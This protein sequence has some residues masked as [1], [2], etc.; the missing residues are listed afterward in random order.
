MPDFESGAFNRAASCVQRYGSCN[1]S[2][3]NSEA[4]HYIQGSK[5]GLSKQK[6]CRTEPRPPAAPFRH[7][8]AALVTNLPNYASAI[9][10]T[11]EL[12]EAL[13]PLKESAGISA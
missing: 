1:N 13:S 7:L 8:E 10:T 4:H 2:L 12:V 9:V 6:A 3:A 11:H 5:N